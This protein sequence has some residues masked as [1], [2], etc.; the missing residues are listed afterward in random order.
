MTPEEYR[1]TTRR[2][3]FA[4]ISHPDAGKTTLTEKLL[5]YAGAIQLAGSVRGKKKQ[6]AVTSDWMELE[7][8]RG[9]SITS[10]VLEFEYENRR[11]NLL[12]TPGHEDFSEDTFRTLAAV[13]S[14]VMVLDRAKGIE[15]QTRKLFQVCRMRGIPTFA[16]IN[17]MD[18]PGREPLALLGEIEE[19]LGVRA[20]AINWPIGEGDRFRGIFDRERRM[21]HRFDRTDHGQ[22]AGTA[23]SYSLGE[24]GFVAAFPDEAERGALREELELLEGAGEVFDPGQ[25]LQGRLVPV[26]FGSALTNFGVEPFLRR[27]VELAPPP[28]SRPAGGRTVAPDSEHF[29]GFV[30]KVQSNMDPKHRDSVAFLRVCSGCLDRGMTALHV[31]TGK[32]LRLDR[33]SRLFGQERET[34]DCAYPGDI[35]GLPNPGQFVVGD[36][37]CTGPAIHYDE[38]PRFPPEHFAV[39]RNQDVARFKNFRKGLDQLEEEG[40]IQV[41][42][43]PQVARREPVL[44]AVG[45]LQFDVVQFRLKAEYNV[46]TALEPLEYRL[47]R[48]VRG[49]EDALEELARGAYGP[50]W[51]ADREGERVLLFRNEW[52]AKRY[53]EQ[54]PEVTLL[55]VAA[56]FRH[57]IG[58]EKKE[59]SG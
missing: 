2:R 15:S 47:A 32:P 18:R 41:L 3:T 38:I 25:F 16:F 58:A 30:F 24:A 57:I 4:I 14:A 48:W 33:A 45:R 19:V 49:E 1:E 27:F 44:A 11:L 7:R 17:K 52:E 9:I 23:N 51:L 35:V 34:I 21:A 13:D 37:L 28:R 46:E 54:H 8:Q 59:L 22:S 50:L 31:R 29:S 39:L 53:G 36:T 40:A 42:H 5:L 26:F 43:R 6:A 10:T 20:V 12:D 56:R 55:D